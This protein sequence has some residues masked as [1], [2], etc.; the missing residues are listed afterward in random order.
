MQM[1]AF[2]VAWPSTKILQTPS[3]KSL[4]LSELATKFNLV[5]QGHVLV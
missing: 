2:F 1:R 3:A 4:A 5:Y